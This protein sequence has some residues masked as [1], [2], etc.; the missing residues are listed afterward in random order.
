MFL[1]AVPSSQTYCVRFFYNMFGFHINELILSKQSG[2]NADT[3]SYIWSIAHQ[4]GPLWHEFKTSV[5][6]EAGDRLLL[7]ALRGNAYSGDIAVD[8][9]S[10]DSG[11]C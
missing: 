3:R 1:P 5:E 11:S 9:I 8:T 2:S 4:Q 10:V 7:T 6:L